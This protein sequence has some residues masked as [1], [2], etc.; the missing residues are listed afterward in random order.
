MFCKCKNATLL[1]KTEVRK[2]SNIF[3]TINE[4]SV[5]IY[6]EKGL[7]GY[8]AADQKKAKDMDPII[9]SGFQKALP[10]WEKVYALSP[11]DRAA[12]IH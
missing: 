4:K 5:N 9:K 11:K 6:K 12:H 1:L 2:Q 8:S 7:L 3:P 10:A